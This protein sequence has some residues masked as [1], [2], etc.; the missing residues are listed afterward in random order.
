[1]I[2]A[3]EP[4]SCAATALLS[5]ERILDNISRKSSADLQLA[6]EVSQQSSGFLQVDRIEA[7]SEPAVDLHPAGQRRLT[8]EAARPQRLEQF[9]FTDQAVAVL[10]QIGQE[11]EYLRLELDRPP[12]GAQLTALQLEFIV[13]KA[14]DHQPLPSAA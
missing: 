12:A 1:L 3:H 6:A 4:E 5:R 10:E 8:N 2:V 7:L 14:V 11:I 9:F 13:V